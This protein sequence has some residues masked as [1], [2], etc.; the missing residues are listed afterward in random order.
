MIAVMPV[1]H[2]E[3]D[4]DRTDA[5]SRQRCHLYGPHRRSA[6]AARCRAGQLSHTGHDAGP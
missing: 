3:V 4:R 5:G 6:S 1:I 2:Q